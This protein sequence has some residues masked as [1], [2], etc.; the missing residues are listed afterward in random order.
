MFWKWRNEWN[1]CFYLGASSPRC[2]QYNNSVSRT[3]MVV[4]TGWRTQCISIYWVQKKKKNI[5]YITHI[6]ELCNICVFSISECLVSIK[7][8]QKER[9]W[10]K[11]NQTNRIW[12]QI[13]SIS[14]CT[15]GIVEGKNRFIFLFSCIKSWPLSSSPGAER[16]TNKPNMVVLLTTNLHLHLLH[17]AVTICQE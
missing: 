17:K 7:E 13:Y 11:K 15:C 5:H 3:C 4:M 12:N 16:R 14:Q 1:V 2:G 10:K 8:K 6:V 9:K